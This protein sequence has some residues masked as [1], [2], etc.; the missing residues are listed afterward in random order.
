MRIFPVLQPKT[1]GPCTL[2][3]KVLAVIDLEPPKAKDIW[4]R[5]AEKGDGCGIYEA[6]PESCRTF[7]CTWLTDFSS[8]AFRPDKIHG[9]LAATLDGEN[10][11]LHEDPGYRMHAR[12]AL[13][14]FIESFI[15]SGEHYV[16]VVCGTERL[17]MGTEERL[18]RVTVVRDADPTLDHLVDEVT[19]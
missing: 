16:V 1:C 15:K 4:C 10:I 6:R 19:P 11:V 5:Y 12:D 7:A 14:W 9:V 17:L 8:E 3:C 13:R 18:K 2:C